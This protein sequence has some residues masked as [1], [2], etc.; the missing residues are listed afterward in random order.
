MPSFVVVSWQIKDQVAVGVQ[1]WVR[2]E[3]VFLSLSPV[4]F[5]FIFIF[6]CFEGLLPFLLLY[7]F[8]FFVFLSLLSCL[9]LGITSDFL[10]CFY[11]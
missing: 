3:G 6:Y 11:C 9:L 8:I 1:T 7:V 4:L 10:A 5:V 2:S